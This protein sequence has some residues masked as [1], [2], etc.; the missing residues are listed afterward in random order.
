MVVVEVIVVVIGGGGGHPSSSTL[1]PIA[2]NFLLVISSN[3]GRISY[4]F[5]NI[6]AQFAQSYKIPVPRSPPHPCLTPQLTRNPSE[7]LDKSYCRRSRGMGLLYDE[8]RMI[9]MSALR[10]CEV[11]IQR[12][13][14]LNDV[15]DVVVYCRR[16]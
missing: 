8:K 1:V 12:R 10:C 3:F 14:F 4:S 11:K 2:C 13:L 6:D 7:F 9:L 15:A 16:H 5:R